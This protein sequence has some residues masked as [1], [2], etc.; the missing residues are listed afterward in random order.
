MSMSLRT[1]LIALA[2][3]V[4]AAGAAQAQGLSRI[5][6]RQAQQ[7]QRISQGVASG[8]LTPRETQRL[9]AQQRHIARYERH[10]RADGYLRAHER[11]HLRALQAHASRDIRWQ[12][13]DAQ[14]RHRR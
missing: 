1:P 13:R 7:A 8:Q 10:A 2:L 5:D 11:Q 12:K 3:A 4:F 14:Q 9:L 6:Q